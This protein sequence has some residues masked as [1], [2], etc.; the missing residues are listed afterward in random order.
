[1]KRKDS[2]K[3]LDVLLLSIPDILIRCKEEQALCNIVSAS[4]RK[5]QTLLDG[6][7]KRFNIQDVIY[8]EKCTTNS[9]EKHHY[10]TFLKFLGFKMN[11]RILKPNSCAMVLWKRSLLALYCVSERMIIA[12][13]VLFIK[14]QYDTWYLM[15]LFKDSKSKIF[16]LNGNF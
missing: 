14:N 11:F 7:N 12:G 6:F 5:L 2:I 3:R 9:V 8:I 16:N 15:L 4:E 1:M 13:I 10:E